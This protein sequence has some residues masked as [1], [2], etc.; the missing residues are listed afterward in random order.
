M[1]SRVRTGLATLLLSVCGAAWAQ[2]CAVLTAP[3]THDVTCEGM[4]VYTRVPSNC[5]ASGCGLIL[6]IHGDGGTGAL[7]DAHLKLADL[8][9]DAGYVLIAPT[10]GGFPARDEALVA[11]TR[12]FMEALNVD[13][14]KIHVTGFSR[15][16][17]AVWRLACNHQDLFASIA[18]AAAGVARPGETSC[19]SEGPEPSRSIPILQLIGLNDQNVPARTQVAM[20]DLLVERW[21]LTGPE[22][23]SAD[24]NYAH[25]RWSRP[26]GYL[27]EV[28]EHRYATRR[29]GGHCV[30]GSTAYDA[31][32]Y[33]YGCAPPNAFNWGEEVMRFFQAHPMPAN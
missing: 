18:P 12:R 32:R 2:E 14:R 26:D 30:P 19:F 24:D 28:F 6:E 7:Q 23:I 20:R 25:N 9:E 16:G 22:R 29:G 4:P 33:A 3:G 1:A 13:R 21:Q 15:G 31:P 11:I 27:L 5:P 10:G 8:G 17:Y